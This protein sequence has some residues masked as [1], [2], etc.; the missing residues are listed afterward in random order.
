M[1]FLHKWWSS[2]LRWLKDTGSTSLNF[3]RSH[4]KA[5][6]ISLLAT[7]VLAIGTIFTY[8]YYDSNVSTLYHVKLN[9]N[10]IGVVSDPEVVND[11]I[12]EYLSEKKEE[13]PTLTLKI[14]DKIEFEAESVYRGKTED[15]QV[16]SLLR[17][18]VKVKAEALKLVVN[19]ETVGYVEDAETLENILSSIKSQFSGISEKDIKLVQSAEYN[20]E[21]DNGSD[22]EDADNVE[23]MNVA[24]KDEIKSEQEEVS[25]DKVLSPDEL[26][27]LLVKGDVEQ[28]IYH[29]QSGDCLSCI[30]AKFDMA[31]ADLKA[32][33]PGL[34]EDTVLQIGQ[35]IVVS[36]YEPKIHVETTEKLVKEESIDYET[37]TRKDSSMFAGERKVIQNGKEGKKKVTYKVMKENGVEQERIKLDEEVVAEPVTRIVAV[38]TKIVPSRGSGR[39]QWPTHGGRVTSGYG[40]RWGKMHAAID[41]AGVSNRTI[42][43]ADAGTVEFAGWKGGY[44]NCIIINHNNGFKTLYGH[45]S[46]IKVSRGQKVGKGQAIGIMGTTGHSTGVHLHFEIIHN[47]SKVNP[48]T[49]LR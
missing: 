35:E 5:T 23:V 14:D 17:R 15:K 21:S 2:F 20:S 34:T 47:G 48:L 31:T 26:K 45:L 10:E 27:E 29:V 1:S 18:E 46:S 12:E 43:A 8:H 3:F 9:G 4:R 25:P 41:I 19:G 40:Y 32:L 39:F 36:G 13:Y 44:G 30:A 11:W 7:L 33:N 6:I 24:I 16:L 37:E 28:K 49:Y 22:K 42:M 38:G